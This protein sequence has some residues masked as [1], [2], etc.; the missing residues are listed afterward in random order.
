[1]IGAGHLLKLS[2][3]GVIAKIYRENN[4]AQLH[5]SSKKHQ[6]YYVPWFIHRDL[7]SNP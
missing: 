6:N 2:A 1:M 7:L 3:C 5:A 4:T